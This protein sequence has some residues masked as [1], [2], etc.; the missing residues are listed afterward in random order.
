M[1]SLGY[2]RLV[3]CVGVVLL[4]SVWVGR[5]ATMQKVWLDEL[6]LRYMSSAGEEAQRNLAVGGS[7][8]KVARQRF[9][10]GVGTHALSCVAYA[11]EGSAEQFEAWVG[12]DDEEL[13][14]GRGSAIFRVYADERLVAET[15]LIVARA[16]AVLL[17]ANLRGARSVTLE[18]LDGGDGNRHDHAD[19][20][21][22]YF[23]VTEGTTLKALS[24]PPTQQYGILTPA[25][26]A[27]PRINGAA[28]FGVRPEHPIL[29]K[30]AASG[31]KP[32]RYSARRL[33]RGVAI[34]A[35][36][37]VVS[38][39]LA[40]PGDYP[41]KVTVKNRH[42]RDTREVV[43]RVGEEIALT[44]PMGWNSWNCFADKVSAGKIK[45]AADALVDS[46]L[47]DYG[48]SYI[49]IDDYWQSVPGEK[50]D[51]SLMGAARDEQGRIVPN[52]RFPDMRG[53]CDY[54][55]AKG[56]KVGIYSSPGATTCGG[57]VGSWQHEQLDAAS[58]AAWGI[59]YLKYD[60]CSYAAIARDE[61]L[62]ELMQPYLKMSRALR[63]Q[64][65]DIVFSLCQY[66]MGHVAAWGAR[67]GGNSWR[68]TVDIIDTWASVCEI[69]EAQVGLEHFA[70]PGSWNDPD[71]LVVGV[72]G[73][74]RAHPTRLT[75]NQQYAHLSLWCLLS[76][77]L[78]LGC[79]LEKLDDF[80]VGLLS[81]AEVLAI[82]QDVAGRQAE[83]R[84]QSAT[85]ETWVKRLDGGAVALGLFNRSCMTQTVTLDLAALDLAG[86]W[87]TH[88]LWRQQDLGDLTEKSEFSLPG[89]AVLLLLLEKESKKPE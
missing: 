73:W 44:P 83:R 31:E 77:P 51:V 9:E 43:L 32:L 52:K 68:T 16:S 8:L 67:A 45:R 40:H 17:R 30:V 7:Q 14:R 64:K 57:C 84:Q 33:P 89:S 28:I 53:L 27:T 49:N 85:Q 72:V 46:G 86:T 4:A 54:I 3:R 15:G 20:C 5:A 81:N 59:D 37:G 48:W 63:A 87:R 41:I 80:T 25:A 2:G 69:A 29:Y 38:G 60:W 79:D 42:G 76:A 56:L 35:T 18:V 65:R 55:H 39:S 74:G 13:T 10:R 6:D 71:M 66:G 19:W 23:S 34:D 24:Q 26:A 21:E 78:L 61:S 82:N 88:D 36:T 62:K 11:I 12:I 75:P 70:R 58:Y 50:E 47:S 22:A 1:R